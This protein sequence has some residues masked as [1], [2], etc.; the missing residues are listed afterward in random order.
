MQKQNMANVHPCRLPAEDLVVLCEN[1][2][3]SEDFAG[4]KSIFNFCCHDFPPILLESDEVVKAQAVLALLEGRYSDLYR[5]L[6]RHHFAPQHHERL[7]EL[8]LRGHCAEVE[9]SR[10]QS[11]NSV[12]R[13]RLRKRFPPP[14]TI[15]DGEERSYFFQRRSRQLLKDCY[16]HNP[17]P[18]QREKVDL[19]KQV[20][21]TRVQVSNWFKNRRHRDRMGYRSVPAQR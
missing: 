20:G 11:V 10:G 7:Q 21:L 13:H 16:A 6:E 8:W 12:G 4:L 1:L 15:W 2:Q 9:E 5:M 14:P 17:Y 19:A 18:S 3:A